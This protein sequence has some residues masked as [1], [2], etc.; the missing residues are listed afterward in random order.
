VSRSDP[1]AA[2]SELPAQLTWLGHSTVLIGLDG[3][4]LLTD[5]LLRRR[6]A[7][8]RHVSP[9]TPPVVDAVL[10]SHLHYDHLDLPSLRRL[11]LGV[12][13][14]VPVGAGRLLRR[15]GF[16]EVVELAEGASVG[17]G[18][19]NV[20]AVHADHGEGRQRLGAHGTA[21][22]Y[23]VEGSRRIYFAGDTG[24][25]PGM[26]ALAPLDVA[27]LPVAGWGKKVGPGHLGPADA[28]K[29]LQL[30]RPRIAVP[31]HWGTVRP[32]VSRRHST[33]QAPHEFAEHAARLAPEV[34]VHVLGLGESLELP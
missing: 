8:L 32:I 17:V 20:R 9:A 12:R 1:V 11:G 10:V 18:S 31:V 21:L 25:F 5:P 19:V 3:A 34:D 7:H 28:A 29:S 13:V 16:S 33:E 15:N 26:A 27:L 22:G 4:R 24:V 6:V 30:L 14:V 2:A 23:V